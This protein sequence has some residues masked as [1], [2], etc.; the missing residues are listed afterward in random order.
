MQSVVCSDA[1]LAIKSFKVKKFIYFK[2]AMY[3]FKKKGV[4]SI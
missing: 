3:I 1:V 4:N 2:A